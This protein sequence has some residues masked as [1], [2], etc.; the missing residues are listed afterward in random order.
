MKY[1]LFVGAESGLAKAAIAE[2]EKKGDY[3]FFCCDIAYP[4][5]VC[6][7]NK[8]FLHLDV[9]KPEDFEKAKGYVCA[10]T[11]KLDLVSYFAG[12]VTLGSLVELAPEALDKIMS[13]NLLGMSRTNNVFFGLVSKAKGRI[14]NI[15]SEY[16][17]ICALPFHGYY[18]IS[19][20]A[21]EAYNDSLRRELMGQGIKVVA[22]RPGAFA[23][24][25]QAGVVGQFEK[26]VDDTKLYKAQLTKMSGMMVKELAKAKDPKIFARVFVKAATSKRPKKYYA[27]NNSFKMKMLTA[28]GPSMQDWAL[29]KFL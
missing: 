22:I 1:A 14:I 29:K 25:M 17:K 13:I 19:K 11:D 28:I 4:D 15:S 27:V 16:G 24:N 7:G 12:I 10:I 3:E 21:V 2:L 18:G 5:Y 6:E 9:T 23:T 20:H 26:V 8:H